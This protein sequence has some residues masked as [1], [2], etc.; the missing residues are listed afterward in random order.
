IRVSVDT[1]GNNAYRLP[2]QTRAQHLRREKATSNIC[3]NQAL[4]AMMTT[5]F[6]TVYGKEGLKDLAV[7]NLAKAK[8][9]ADTLGKSGNL[10]FNGAPRFH[11]F[12]LDLSKDAEA[13]NTKLLEKKIIGGLPLAKWY[14][15]LGPNASLWCATE[16]TT[17]QQIDAAAEALK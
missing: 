9:A 7:Q 3:T 6:L 12:V 10:L 5:V 16:L 8:Y 13:V 4:V 1:E 11:E 2:L 17:K 15:E 14:P